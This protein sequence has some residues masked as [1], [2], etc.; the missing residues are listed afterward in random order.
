MVKALKIFAWGAAGLALAAAAGALGLK[1]YFSQARLKTLTRDYAAKNLGREVTFDTIA[2]GLSG[3]SIAN[4]RVSEYPISRANSSA[5]P[6]FRCAPPSGLLRME[7]R[8]NYISAAGLNM[9]VAE[10]KK[11]TYNFSDLLAPAAPAR[12]Q[13]A[14]RRRPRRPLYLQP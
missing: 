5:P 11:D 14:I 1:L 8:I 9:R 6:P 10:L 4:L 7:I 13:P 12:G 2:L 3:L